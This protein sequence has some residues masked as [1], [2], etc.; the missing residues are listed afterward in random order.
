MFPQIIIICPLIYAFLR[1]M[2][3]FKHESLRILI[4]QVGEVPTKVLASI[5]RYLCSTFPNTECESKAMQIPL[6]WEA[7]DATRRQFVSS[8]I[9]SKISRLQVSGVHRILGVMDV[10]IFFRGLNFV[11]GEAQLGGTAALISIYRLKPEFYGQKPNEELLFERSGKEAIHEVGHTLGLRHCPNP[12]CVMTFSNN[13]L[14]VDAKSMEFCE[15]CSRLV[16]EGIDLLFK[17][18]GSLYLS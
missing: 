7:F 13:I 12:Q 10:D 1:E 14:M 17:N 15:R 6:P 16:Q 8:K 9:L 5:A 18:K 3:T 4:L 2:G 11:F